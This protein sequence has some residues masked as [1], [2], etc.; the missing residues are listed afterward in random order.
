MKFRQTF[1]LR[2]AT[3]W[4]IFVILW[5]T[6]WT[7]DR[8]FYCLD[9]CLLVMLWKNRWTDFHIFHEISRTTR[10]IVTKTVLCQQRLLRSLPSRCCT[11]S[12]SNIMVKLMSGFSWN[13][14]YR[15]AM[16]QGTYN[17]E[18]FGD[19]PF[20]HMDRELSFSVCVSNNLGLWVD[21]Y[22]WNFQNMDKSKIWLE[23]FTPEKTVSRSSN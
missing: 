8:F 19:D 16:T 17:L 15:S 11:V 2:Q 5:L 3:N 20:N 13:F 12:A 7:W 10:V 4:N 14:Q 21:G 18:H 22:Y 23:F 6:P 1:Q 9:L